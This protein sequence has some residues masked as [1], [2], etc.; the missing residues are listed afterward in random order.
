MLPPL[1][2]AGTHVSRRTFLTAAGGA[3]AAFGLAGCAPGGTPATI[4]FHQSKPEAVPYFRDLA[5]KF[6][7]SQNSVW[8]HSFGW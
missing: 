6:T 8:T 2:S 5:A 3:L 1:T 7:A 4:T